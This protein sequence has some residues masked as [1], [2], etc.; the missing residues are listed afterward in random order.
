MQAA[1]GI[2]LSVPGAALSFG[3]A[4][5]LW[6]LEF[7][8]GTEVEF[9]TE[10][11]KKW[12]REGATAHRTNSLK[13]FTTTRSG[14]TVTN[15]ARTIVDLSRQM[16]PGQVGALIDQSRILK[17]CS[18]FEVNAC[19][20]EL[21]RTGRRR[22]RNVDEALETRL[23]ND[24]DVDSFLEIRSLK[25]IHRNGLP[26]P[27]TQKW[28]KGKRWYWLDIWYPHLTLNIEPGGPWH[29]LPS[30]HLKDQIRD[31]DLTNCGIQ[32]IRVPLEM[33]ESTFVDIVRTAIA[34]RSAM[35]G[36]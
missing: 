4:A 24:K 9:T 17:V 34:S 12:E 13:S 26:E 19:L 5:R 16:T 36:V 14:I 23:M 7:A 3:A 15:A 31:A 1:S 25:W 29:L 33:E 18:A 30:V 2:T 10:G 11:S 28:F 32:V 6:G 20:D 21:Q 8:A 27:E 22:T 35:F